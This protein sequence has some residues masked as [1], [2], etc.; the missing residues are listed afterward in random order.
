[1]EKINISNKDINILT[2]I[3]KCI[4]LIEGNFRGVMIQ[5]EIS[6]KG[7]EMIKKNISKLSDIV[8]DW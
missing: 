5:K 3:M 6:D 8:A 4:G 7:K 2:E 1:M